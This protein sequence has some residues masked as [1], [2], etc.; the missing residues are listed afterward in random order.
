M[1]SVT[2]DRIRGADTSLALKAPCRA[3]T[4]ANITL[5][6]E[7]TI[8]GVAVVAD[9]RV[10]VKNQTTASENGIYIAATGAWERAPD[11]DGARD[12]V[13]GTQVRVSA[14]T[15]AAGLSYYISTA[16]PITIGTTSISFAVALFES[17]SSAAAAAASEAAAEAAQT[18]AEAAQ[19]AA[20]AAS[21]AASALVA[22]PIGAI[23]YDFASSTSMADPS[24]GNF[25]LNNATLASVTAIAISQ[26][27]T[28]ANTM[29]PYILQ[30]DDSTTTSLRGTLLIR[31]SVTPTIFAVYNITGAS[32]DNTTWVQL[33]VT[34]VTGSGTFVAGSTFNLSFIRSGDVGA[35]GGGS[36]NVVSTNYGTEYSGDYASLRSNIGLGAEDSPQFTGIELGH[37]TDTTITRTSSGIIAVEGVNQIGGSTGATDNVLLRA[38][39]TNTAKL[40]AT[41]VTVDDND[42]IYGYKANFNAQTGTTYTLVAGDTGKTVTLNNASAITVTLPNSLAEG[43]ECECIQLGAGQVTFSA[44]AGAT[45]NNRQSHSKMAGQHAAVRLK[46]T[47]NSGG[48]SAVYNLAGDT[49]T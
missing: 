38:D 32:T 48:S 12:V 6:G 8:D 17:S 24:S 7:Q 45:L 44:G 10:L 36:G 40:Q 13:Q 42:Q 21:A 25:R 19:T 4:T 41:G 22:N 46:V 23:T 27:D 31:D 49:G 3:A 14:G 35:S 5:S 2:T 33:A 26:A 37:A 29:R 34:Y 15:V 28:D 30:W 11:F 20:E 18:A 16:D 1:V 43:F 47:G 39:G 9:D